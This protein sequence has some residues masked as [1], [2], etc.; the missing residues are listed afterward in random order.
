MSTNGS[1]RTP[2]INA[3]DLVI[4]CLGGALASLRDSLWDEGFRDAAEVLA[5]LSHRCD[6]YVEEV[7]QW[8]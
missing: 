3:G 1:S 6:R 8:R 2:H 4:W 5:D 7:Q